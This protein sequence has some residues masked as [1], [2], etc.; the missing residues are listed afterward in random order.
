[1]N[2][3]NQKSIEFLIIEN[4]K[5]PEEKTKWEI[6]SDLFYRVQ[7]CHCSTIFLIEESIDE[8]TEPEFVVLC[9]R[10]FNHNTIKKGQN[11]L[12]L[13]LKKIM[14]ANEINPYYAAIIERSKAGGEN[15][16]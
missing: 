16:E 2:K 13:Q 10:C 9:P 8:R 3:K 11:R 12:L 14:A 15:R 4:K 1:M 5:T 7:C 6:E